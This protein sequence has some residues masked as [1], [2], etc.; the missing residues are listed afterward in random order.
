MK[1]RL[2]Q[3]V[4]TEVVAD[5]FHF[6]TSMAFDADGRLYVAESGLPFAGAPAGGRVYRVV[7][8]DDG[9]T[10]LADDLIPLRAQGR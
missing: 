5:G 4:D 1:T 10:L 6:P 9:R 2:E 8:D 3:T 7:D